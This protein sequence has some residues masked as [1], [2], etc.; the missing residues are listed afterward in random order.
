MPIDYSRSLSGL[1]WLRID[2]NLIY[3]ICG[4][5]GGVRVSDFARSG[6]STQVPAVCHLLPPTL[7][8]SSALFFLVWYARPY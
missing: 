2:Q 7:H 5:A 4:Q 8:A 1:K 3:H 6:I